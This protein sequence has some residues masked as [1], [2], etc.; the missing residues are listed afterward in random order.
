MVHLCW[1]L[2]IEKKQNFKELG[3][4]LHQSAI[5]LKELEQ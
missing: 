1:D 5:C 4:I 2:N 3:S